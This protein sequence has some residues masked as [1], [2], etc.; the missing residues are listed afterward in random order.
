MN[1]RTIAAPERTD[2][3][4]RLIPEYPLRPDHRPHKAY[5]KHLWA[6]EEHLKTIVFR[7]TSIYASS[8][9][10]SIRQILIRT[11]G[12]QVFTVVHE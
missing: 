4:S 10:P 8:N 5:A 9:F 1:G 6:L 3:P 12:S 11:Q 2:S 7:G